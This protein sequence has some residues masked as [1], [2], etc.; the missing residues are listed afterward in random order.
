MGS[1]CCF[2]YK[3]CWQVHDLRCSWIWLEHRL[4]S[5]QV[6][7]GDEEGLRIMSG[8]RLASTPAILVVDPVTG[9]P[10]RTWTGFMGPDRC[11]ADGWV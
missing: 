10:M 6:F 3:C 1:V 4:V 7:T 2:I 9:A 8:Y 5:S 11:A